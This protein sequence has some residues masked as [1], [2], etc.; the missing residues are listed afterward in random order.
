MDEILE[1]DQQE[2]RED[3][4]AARLGVQRRFYRQAIRAAVVFTTAAAA[5]ASLRQWRQWGA[6]NLGGRT[7]AL[8]Q[9]PRNP[10]TIYAG[11]AQGGVFRSDDDGDT[12]QPIGT[13]ADSFPV[14]A[15]ALAPSN[16]NILYVGTGEPGIQHGPNPPPPGV[17]VGVIG[18]EVFAAGLGF[19]RYDAATGIFT[20]EVG[21]A[22]PAPGTAGAANSYAAIAV[23]PQ[24]P[25]RCWIASH[26]GLWRREATA[27]RFRQEVLSAPPLPGPPA[28][29]ACVTDVIVV[30]NWDPNRPTTYRIYA[31]VAGTGIFRG[32]FSP[33]PAPATVWDPILTG[34][35]PAPG[36]LGAMPYD[37]IRVAACQSFPNHVYALYEDASDN[38]I[39][40]VFRSTDGGTTWNPCAVPADLGTQAWVNLCIAV[41]P[42][43]PAVV[44]VGNVNV[45]RS[46]DAGATWQTIIDWGNFSSIDRA[47]HGDT[48]ALMFDQREPNRLWVAND[49]GISSAPDVVNANPMTARTWRKRS[50]G[51]CVSQF[52]DITSHPNYPFMI[53]GGLQDNATYITFGGPTWV[54]VGDADGGEMSFELNTPRQFVVPNQSTGNSRRNLNQSRVVSGSQVEPQPG[55][56]PIVTRTPIPDLQTPPNDVFAAQISRPLGVPAGMAGLFVQNTLHHPV[57]ANNLLAGRRGLNPNPGDV[58]FSTDGGANYA[59]GGAGANAAMVPRNSVTAMAYGAGAT[60]AASDWWIGTDTGV[61][62]QGTGG[63]APKP[64][65]NNLTPPVPAPGLA[66]IIFTRIAVHPNNTNYIVAATGGNGGAVVQGRIFLTNNLGVSWMDITGLAA[67]SVLG[68]PPPGAVGGTLNALPPCPITS[69]AFDPTIAAASPQVLYA[70]TLAGVFVIRNLPR[71]PAGPAPIA[72]PAA[73]NP[74][75]L[76]FNGP[77]A[78]PLPLT[79]VNDL[80]IVSLPPRPGATAN[81]PESAQRLRLYAAMFGRGIFVCDISPTYPA[82][83]PQGGPPRRLVIRQHVIEDGLAYPRPTPTV[84]NTAPAAPNYNQPQMQGDP[85]LPAVPTPIPVPPPIGA[86]NDHTGID[87]RVDNAPFQFFD[88]VIDGVEFDEELRTKNLVPG[89]VNAI[90]VQVQNTGW[91]RFA[92]PVDVH[93]FFAAGAAPAAGADPP[94]LPDLH[95]NFWSNFTVEPQLPPAAGPLAAGAAQWQRTGKKQSIPANRLSAAYPAVLRFEWTPPVSLAT[96]GFVG[97]LAVCTNAEDPLPAPAAMPLVMRALIRQER[98]VAFRLVAT[99]PYTP[100]VYIRDSADD[101]GRAASGSFAGRSPDIIVVQSAVPAP[102]TAFNDLLDT[103]NGDRIRPGVPQIIYVRVHNR[104]NVPVLAQVDVLWA[105]P[106]AA[107]SA[108]DAHAPGFDGT[109]WTA[110]TPVGTATVT[111][112]PLGSAFATLTWQASDVPPADTAAGAFNAIGF[113]AL[114]SSAEGARDPAPA[115]TR[116]RD[117]ASFW[118]FFARTADS[119]NAAFRAVLYG[120]GG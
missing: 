108:A 62:L 19:F 102:D 119:N 69:L 26:T 72:A 8:A 81:S 4:L 33:T 31:A 111:V 22:L 23:D 7:R 14:G 47:Q 21:P 56:Y 97:L 82:G 54:P 90:Y 74:N 104:R 118:D 17:A 84:L 12:W 117:A 89:Q 25:D 43:N 77:A 49:G 88:E 11:S 98:R 86:F 36:A 40:S 57:Q 107:T 80:E 16:P 61:L 52:N 15:I 20:N 66:G 29:G 41:H 92:Q 105:R 27:P 64:T 39:L 78:A 34:G 24:V 65:W 2:E 10:S 70:G 79:L 94:P 5:D 63:G 110:I 38:S 55:L 85:R 59:A 67:A 120:D 114:V 58:A 99:D 93:L 37:R 83:V 100:D 48:H 96:A 68:G 46:G 87:I 116:V 18:F 53:G 30:E 103:H 109:K 35:L 6:R 44:V 60:A 115:K 106:N 75:W 50:H 112:P 76:T 32:V 9:N 42:D 101:T 73:F 95:D 13:P 3:G 1:D 71:L 45:A 113:A 28:L 91:D 51:L